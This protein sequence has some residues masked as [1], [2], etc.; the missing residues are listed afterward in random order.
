MYE[1]IR[2]TSQSGPLLTLASQQTSRNASVRRVGV[3]EAHSPRTEFGSSSR[4]CRRH[5]RRRSQCFVGAGSRLE[6]RRDAGTSHF[7]EHMVFKGTASA[8][9]PDIS[10]E[11]ESR[12][13]S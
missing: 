7:L 11:I 3:P 6:S 13:A 4:R 12:A 2:S 1:G 5:A 9:G 10:M 8:D